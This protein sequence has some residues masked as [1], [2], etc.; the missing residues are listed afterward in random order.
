MKEK[1]NVSFTIV[2]KKITYLGKKLINFQ[3]LC[4]GNYNKYS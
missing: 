4:I 1:K 3:N 2:T